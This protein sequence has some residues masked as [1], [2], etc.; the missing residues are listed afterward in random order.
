[1]S[2]CTEVSHCRFIFF[3]LLYEIA[4]RQTTLVRLFRGVCTSFQNIGQKH[5]ISIW[6]NNWF[7]D[8]IF[9]T[10]VSHCLFIL[11]NL[12]YEI[13]YRKTTGENKIKCL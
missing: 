10:D 4:Y 1:M 7:S 9:C 6:K 11:F 13:T 5:K 2:F 3:N 8:V 12:H